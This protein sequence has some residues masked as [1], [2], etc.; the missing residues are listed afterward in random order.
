MTKAPHILIV[1]DEDAIRFTLGALLRRDGC[2][3]SG[4]ASIKDALKILESEPLDII[5]SDILLTNE[6]GIDL[7]HEIKTR[8]RGVQVIMFTGRPEIETAIRAVR[9]GAFD[10]LTKPVKYETMQSVIRLAIK[11]KTIREQEERY[12]ADLDAIFR[13]INDA[14]IMIDPDGKLLQCNDAA[15]ALC[16][17]SRE[18]L[19]GD[20]RTFDL[21]CKGVCRSTIVKA[22]QDGKP[23]LVKRM[24]CSGHG[25][26]KVINLTVT[27][28]LNAEK[29]SQGVVAV[30]RDETRM[31][32]LEQTISR[33]TQN[34]GMVGQNS[35]MQKLYDMIDA[36]V[37]LPTTV[38][39]TGESGTGKELVASALHHG[40]CRKNGPFIKVN[41]SAL[42]ESLLENELFGHVKGAFTGAMDDKKGRF[43]RANGGSIFLDEIGD[44]S[45]AMQMRLLRVLQELVVERVGD[46][47]PIK[48]DV[49]V[50]AA[51]NQNLEEKV[52]QG[53][54]RQDL[55]YRLNVIKIHIPPLRDR[56]DDLPQLADYFLRKFNKRFNRSI[57]G[58]TEPALQALL[59]H[60]WGGNVREL[61]HIIERASILCRNGQITVDDLPE[62][63]QQRPSPLTNGT[64][65]AD[66]AGFPMMTVEEALAACN[67]NKSQ[68]AKLL[69]ISRRTVYR[70]LGVEV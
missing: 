45:P 70:H 8:N 20:I 49:R 42:S 21:G 43:E 17:Y 41:C 10:Y 61:E 56:L 51:T 39:I 44:I 36:L 52:R 50:V 67:G 25:S 69:G 38:L 33:Q 32:Q 15:Y 53:T 11:A 1:D 9:E 35:G 26:N 16:G 29:Q 27:P 3:V 57:D 22:L 7:L 2:I 59:H 64:I 4:A 66:E 40:G 54:F 18:I 28:V 31:V 48:V 62:E 30:L 14:I 68:A 34:H 60:P 37:D 5:F 46:A 55:Y 63:L 23:H 6:N 24:E 12:R 13:S 65:T 47:T 19:G 58:F